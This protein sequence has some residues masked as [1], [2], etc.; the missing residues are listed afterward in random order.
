MHRIV[1]NVS[2]TIILSVVFVIIWSLVF[3]LYRVSVLNDK[4]E[5]IAT[6][7][8]YDISS[9]NYL[10][11]DAEELYQGLF[12]EIKAD[13]NSGDEFVQD[14]RI[15]YGNDCVY[16]PNSSSLNYSED[17]KVPANYGDVAILE[18]TVD[19]SAVT[20]FYDG[21]KEGKANQ[22][23]Q[24]FVDRTFTYVYQIPC[25]RYVSVTS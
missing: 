14:I 5:S 8:Q 21:S 24:T 22:A 10:T 20:W 9:S 12:D 4:I 11:E 7:M 19:I 15:N 2:K 13:M 25:L 3:Y 1:Y 18:I 17:L 16:E 23:Q 6:Y